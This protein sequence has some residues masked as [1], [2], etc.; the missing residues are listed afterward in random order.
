VSDWQRSPNFVGDR[1]KRDPHP[2]VHGVA[3]RMGRAEVGGTPNQISTS[4]N[5]AGDD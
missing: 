5:V 3:K 1:K 4:K 2:I